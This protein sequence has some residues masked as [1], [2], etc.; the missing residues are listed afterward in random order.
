MFKFQRVALAALF[1]VAVSA[2]AFAD[3]ISVGSTLVKSGDLIPV[4]A[5]GNPT[6][7]A[8]AVGFDFLLLGGDPEAGTPGVDG[9]FIVTSRTGD[10]VATI[11][12]FS[13]G[14]ITDFMFNS[15]GIAGFPAPPVTDFEMIGANF[16]FDLESITLVS[17]M[18]GFVN[19]TG[20][21]TFFLDGFDPTPAKITITATSATGVTFGFTANQAAGA[22]V[23]EP[24]SLGLLG[25]G[26]FGVA[27]AARR[28]RVRA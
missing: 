3:P 16:S 28:R 23:P 12:L 20:T 8:L 21:G 11:P 14:T 17:Q 22:V 18:E 2:S 10:F 25:M 26:L 1:T 5:A 4:D 6:T 15:A 9:Q 27:A 7:L 19:L 13:I 24:A